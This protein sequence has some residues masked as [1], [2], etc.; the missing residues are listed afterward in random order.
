MAASAPTVALRSVVD[1]SAVTSATWPL[2]VAPTM[3]R[4][5]AKTRIRRIGRTERR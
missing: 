2:A 1:E 5:A 4:K 3:A